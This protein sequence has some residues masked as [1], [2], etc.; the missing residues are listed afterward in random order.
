[1]T[2]SPDEQ[3][4]PQETLN[5][6][7][8]ADATMFQRQ[9]NLLPSHAQDEKMGEF[10]P[11]HTDAMVSPDDIKRD[12][13]RVNEDISRPD[14]TP[15][16]ETMEDAPFETPH[17]VGLPREVV[18]KQLQDKE[19]VVP[20]TPDMRVGQLRDAIREQCNVPNERQRLLWQGRPLNDD[21]VL[22][23]DLFTS[24]IRPV[25]HLVPIPTDV[26]LEQRQQQQSNDPYVND[27]SSGGGT[28]I[29]MFSTSYL[30]SDTA[31]EQTEPSQSGGG[32]SS[33]LPGLATSSGTHDDGHASSAEE[34]N[35]RVTINASSGMS[36]QLPQMSQAPIF[37]PSVLGRSALSVFT[38][39]LQTAVRAPVTTTTN[40]QPSG[41]GAEANPISQ[42]I[43]QFIT[44]MSEQL[45]RQQP[46]PPANRGANGNDQTVPR[47]DRHRRSLLRWDQL[48][49]FRQG[50]YHLTGTR[51]VPLT[52]LPSE[53][54]LSGSLWLFVTAYSQARSLFNALLGELSLWHQQSCNAP[55]FSFDALSRITALGSSLDMNL[56]AAFMQM[57]V[58]HE[59]EPLDLVQR[60]SSAQDSV[61][62]SVYEDALDEPS[63]SPMADTAGATTGSVTAH[64]AEGRS[65]S[66]A[67]PLIDTTNI[68]HIS[69]YIRPLSVSSAPPQHLQEGL[70]QQFEASPMEHSTPIQSVTPKSELQGFQW[71][72]SQN[73]STIPVPEIIQEP[74][75]IEKRERVPVP[76]TPA[77]D[78]SY[79]EG[80][81]ALSNVSSLVQDRL[82]AWTSDPRKFSSK[83]LP[84]A[85][86]HNPSR[87]YRMGAVAVGD[88]GFFEGFGG[89][90]EDCRVANPANAF[91]LQWH[92]AAWHDRIG[93]VRLPASDLEKLTRL[94]NAQNLLDIATLVE[95]D[96]NFNA[97]RDRYP[98]LSK[99]LKLLKEIEDAKKEE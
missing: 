55:D 76:N 49:E 48:Q 13:A 23:S 11:L 69:A 82:K 39:S 98:T 66:V 88:G 43:G 73:T 1:M 18:L 79:S 19:F 44:D 5:D 2:S 20:I 59:R 31:I 67:P 60:R 17:E 77:C 62:R 72:Q 56:S 25:V 83:I 29:F 50:V 10:P 24:T 33:G 61:D 36:E 93:D 51:Y 91:R 35:V 8:V 37:T 42:F 68:S 58:E 86:F 21:S 16:L 78:L 96:S 99:L 6:E 57:A 40:G 3:K 45:H 27:P 80:P 87:A 34:G 64:A 12:S 89:K 4:P 30:P 65:E 22:L 74:I 84:A 75:H 46:T 53:S 81:T 92:R 71:E 28:T 63:M 7:I 41:G 54:D 90:R 26:N 9:E 38:R 32:E 52:H 85:R 97:E 14:S 15:P 95:K 94:H 47:G 70:Q